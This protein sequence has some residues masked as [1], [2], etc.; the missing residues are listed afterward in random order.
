MVIAYVVFSVIGIIL[1]TFVFFLGL[2]LFGIYMKAAKEDIENEKHS[3]TECA[4]PL[5][6][7]ES[8]VAVDSLANEANIKNDVLSETVTAPIA[9]NTPSENLEKREITDKDLEG[10]KRR[11]KIFSPLPTWLAIEGAILFIFHIVMLILKFKLKSFVDFYVLIAVDVGFAA[12]AT[13]V[14]SFVLSP[15]S[16]DKTAENPENTIDKPE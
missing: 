14:N 15:K 10:I 8:D 5:E 12:L 1:G 7:G 6:V 9:D 13:L 11:E 3:D 16:V 4:N 2:A